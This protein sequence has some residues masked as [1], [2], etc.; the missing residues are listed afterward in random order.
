MELEHTVDYYKQLYANH[1][2]A[3]KSWKIEVFE[4]EKGIHIF[5]KKKKKDIGWHLQYEVKDKN[6]IKKIKE[7][8][9][10]FDSG[11]SYDMIETDLAGR[12]K[13]Y[14]SFFAM[15]D[16][17][18]KDFE[19]FIGDNTNFKEYD[20]IGYSEDGKW[21]IIR[22]IRS[23]IEEL[24]ALEIETGIKYTTIRDSKNIGFEPT[25]AEI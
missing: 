14:I 6:G 9:D 18:E 21:Q 2:E 8:H 3:K 16:Y 20:E 12:T 13:R 7:N 17:H 25:I 24:T 22:K 1:T 10:F 11:Y 15:F 19:S 4:D 5:E 23:G